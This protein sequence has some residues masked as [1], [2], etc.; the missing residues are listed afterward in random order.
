[1]SARG[2]C[3]ELNGPFLPT[4]GGCGET[5]RSSPGSGEAAASPLCQVGQGCCEAIRFVY[6]SRSPAAYR[7]RSWRRSLRGSRRPA[8]WPSAI[9]RFV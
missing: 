1:M 9:A 7:E 6:D 4:T 5:G 3:T 8:A 2:I